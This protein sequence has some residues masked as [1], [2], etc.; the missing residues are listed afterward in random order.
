MMDITGLRVLTWIGPAAIKRH[1]Q[2]LP[3]FG[4]LAW[5]VRRAHVEY[6]LCWRKWHGAT[7]DAWRPVKTRSDPLAWTDFGEVPPMALVRRNAVPGPLTFPDLPS[8]SKVLAK[9]PT[10]IEF[11]TRRSWPDG[12]VRAPGRYWWDPL[13]SGFCLTLIDV[14]NAL[15]IKVTAPTLD[16]AYAAAELVLGT[17]G[18]QWEVDTYEQEKREKKA[19]R[20]K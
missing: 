1:S 19:K 5:I 2:R 4:T 15:R 20:K 10:L 9:F 14:D 12:T 7:I 16:A 17:D 13:S 3:R 8:E 6:Y 18:G 11:L